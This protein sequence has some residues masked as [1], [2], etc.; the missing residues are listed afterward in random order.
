MPITWKKNDV[1]GVSSADGRF[2]ISPTYRHTVRPDG[3]NMYDRWRNVG[4]GFNDTQREAKE[5][6][7][8]ILRRED[9][10]IRTYGFEEP[11]PQYD[12][13]IIRYNIRKR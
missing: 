5:R 9:Y 8:D 11:D 3:W 13:H 12:S 10:I 1:G 7:E 6:A 4:R 2:V